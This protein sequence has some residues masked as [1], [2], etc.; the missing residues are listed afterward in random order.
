MYG[1]AHIKSFAGG[2]KHKTGVDYQIKHHKGA[3]CAATDKEGNQ[4]VWFDTTRMFKEDHEIEGEF[5]MLCHE[6]AHVEH[7]TPQEMHATSTKVAKSLGFQDKDHWFVSELCNALVDIRDE[8]RFERDYPFSRRLMERLYTNIVWTAEEVQAT[9]VWRRMALQTILNSRKYP[10]STTIEDGAL[11]VDKDIHD[12]M[13][14]LGKRMTRKDCDLE[15]ELT[16]MVESLKKYFD[17]DKDKPLGGG[18]EQGD[19]D[20]SMGDSAAT[21]KYREESDKAAGDA[22]DAA[23]QAVPKAGLSSDTVKNTRY[24]DSV[25]YRR[26]R[27]DF[28]R[29]APILME[30]MDSIKLERLSTE[31]VEMRPLWPRIYTDQHMF[32]NPDVTKGEELNLALCLDTSSSMKHVIG[33]AAAICRALA[34]AISDYNSV[35]RVQAWTFAHMTRTVDWQDL[36]KI[37]H[38]EHDTQGSRAMRL[39]TQ[40]LEQWDTGRRLCII[41]T[42]GG[43]GDVDQ[44]SQVIRE[45]HA[46]N[47]EYLLVGVEIGYEMM[48][49]YWP[50]D[51]NMVAIP[52]NR[53]FSLHDI[54][55]EGLKQ[56]M[57]I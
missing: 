56:G 31:G 40:W 38:L 42:D 8:C 22:L 9:P 32:A 1:A 10:R 35:N 45:G 49:E 44:A 57:Y 21:A 41:I 17:P 4:S 16:T 19:G 15:S 36:D 39:A 20:K 3:P 5:G 51:I 53:L 30:T 2:L 54:L 37:S 7:G 24:F 12:D 18:G 34:C 33:R 13:L 48:R 23:F 11:D 6:T 46:N 29:S 52:G 47:I 28:L 50:H 55:L 27:G 43:L 14:K 25:W 26:W